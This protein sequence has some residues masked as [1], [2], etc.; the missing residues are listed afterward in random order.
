MFRRVVLKGGNGEPTAFS[1]NV[2]REA[3][4]RSGGHELTLIWGSDVE[5][6]LGTGGGLDSGELRDFFPALG[7]SRFY[8]QTLPPGYGIDPSR[9]PDMDYEAIEPVTVDSSSLRSTMYMSN[10][11]HYTNTVDCGVIISGAVWLIGPKGQESELTAGTAFIDMGAPH[12]WENRSTEPC[13]F[14]L[15][16]VGANRV[17]PE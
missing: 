17:D 15:F 7:G 1:D 11:F 10:G 8:L 5:P 6:T 2:V 12:A 4:V 14:A 9:G 16:I 3:V 13:T